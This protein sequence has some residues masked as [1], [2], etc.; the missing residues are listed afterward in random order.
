M[1]FSMPQLTRKDIREVSREVSRE[2][3][4]EKIE[5][6]FN[7]VKAE[8]QE[9]KADIRHI[10]VRLDGFALSLRGLDD[11]VLM[12]KNHDQEITVLSAQNKRLDGRVT[13]LE[14]KED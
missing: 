4:D 6:F 9:V 11:L 1:I 10:N 7:W 2:V 13:R 14:S 3:F 5:P 12:Y 8:F